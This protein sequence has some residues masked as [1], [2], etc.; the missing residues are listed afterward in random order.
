MTNN[1]L[2][3]PYNFKHF[4]SMKRLRTMSGAWWLFH[5]F[6][7]NCHCL[8]TTIACD[9]DTIPFVEVAQFMRQL[10]HDTRT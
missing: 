5:R 3:T 4:M 7:K 8:A 10:S 6:Q 9:R 2:A 1:F